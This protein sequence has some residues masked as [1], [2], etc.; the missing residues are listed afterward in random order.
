[1][2]LRSL[3]PVVLLASVVAGCGNNSSP[4][5]PTEPSSTAP[6]TSVAPATPAFTGVIM[7]KCTPTAWQLTGVAPGTGSTVRRS[8]PLAAGRSSAFGCSSG[9]ST[10][11]VLRQQFDRDFTRLAVSARGTDGGTHV[12]YVTSGG[13]FVDLSAP[14][15]GFADPPRQD[16]AMVN[17]AT[18]RIWYQ[19]LDSMG[20]VDPDAGPASARAEASKPFANGII[21]G[22]RNIYYFA[23][24]GRGPLNLGFAAYRVYSPDGRTEVQAGGAFRI[25][26]VD[27]VDDA[28]PITEL[29]E[30][31]RGCWP[32]WFM[33]ADS[34]LCVDK[35]NTQLYKMVIGADRASLTQTPL[36]PKT[37]RPVGSAVAN[38]DGT[39]VAFIS[40]ISGTPALYTVPTTGG[41]EPTRIASVEDAKVDLID[42]I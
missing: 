9:S 16:T 8:F 33:T 32:K 15:S 13:A 19:G 22:S 20:S 5:R 41:A 38:A 11:R 37:T 28:T 3:L 23:P 10:G 7:A 18:G 6:T 40:A 2:T 1:M 25:G 39:Q 21:G 42:W 24:N 30:G 17:P 4:A 35:D 29:P 36:L 14:P 34:F 12:G 27:A 26:D 31:A